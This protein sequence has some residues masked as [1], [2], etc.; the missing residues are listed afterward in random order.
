MHVWLEN[1]TWCNSATR[2]HEGVPGHLQVDTRYKQRTQVQLRHRLAAPP[3][4]RRLH[5]PPRLLIRVTL[6]LHQ[7]HCA[8]RLL[9]ATTSC[10]G[11][12]STTPSCRLTSHQSVALALVVRPVSVSCGTTTRRSDCTGSTVPMS[13]IRT[14]HLD[15][16]S[17]QSVTLAL[18]VCPV[19]SVVR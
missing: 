9:T 14:R 1:S 2:T 17:R 6:A 11:S 8:P 15:S 7:L 18:T 19:Y 4:L 16:T 12:T 13:C 10:S 5:V 3:T